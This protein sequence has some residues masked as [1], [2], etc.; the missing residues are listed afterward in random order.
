MIIHKPRIPGGARI[1]CLNSRVAPTNEEFK[2]MT[3]KDGQVQE[4]VKLLEIAESK[5]I[6]R[7][8]VAVG[9]ELKHLKK[10]SQ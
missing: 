9:R 10:W 1:Q 3:Q 8:K 4:K 2:L 6:A 7:E 5:K